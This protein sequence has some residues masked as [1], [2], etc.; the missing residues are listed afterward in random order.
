VE[1]AIEPVHGTWRELD[2]LLHDYF[3]RTKAKEGIPPLRMNWDVF[4]KLNEQGHVMLFTARDGERLVG[5]ALY[6]IHA[7][8]HHMGMMAASCDILA[9]DVDHR[10]KGIATAMLK[11]AEHVF[12]NRGI[13]FITQGS[14]TC[15]DV[16]PLFPKLGYRLIEQGYMKELN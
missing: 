9:V 7:H 10:G 16:E 15:Y 3:S 2:I 8:L 6:Y 5:F 11:Y 1:I 4:I 12:R 14:R 13:D